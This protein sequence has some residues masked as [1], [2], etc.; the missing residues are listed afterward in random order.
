MRRVDN[1]PEPWSDPEAEGLPT[2][3]DDDSY[4]WDEVDSPREADGP[5][6]APLPSDNPV[7]VNRFGT[8]PEEA[9]A[10]ESLDRKLRREVPDPAL[11]D[12]GERADARSSPDPVEAFDPEPLNEDLDVV[13]RDTSLDTEPDAAPAQARPD[14]PVSVYDTDANLRGQVGRLVEPDEGLTE[15]TEPDMIA[16]DAGAAGGGPT[17]EELA[18]HE[19]REP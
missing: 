9:R 17:A 7:A 2:T 13:D 6:P 5:D 3:A 16:Y 14:S 8:T 1:F 10:G 19:V 18:M 4:A 12:P 15:D 11:A